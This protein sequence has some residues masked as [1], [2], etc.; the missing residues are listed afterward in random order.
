MSSIHPSRSRR[1]FATV[2]VCFAVLAAAVP[3]ASAAPPPQNP[4][5][6]TA[7]LTC[8]GGV[9]FT[10][11]SIATSAGSAGHVVAGVEATTFVLTQV[12]FEG[13]VVFSIPGPANATTVTGCTSPAYP[14]AV[15]EGF[16]V[17]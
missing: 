10:T 15:L 8:D 1:A 4:N 3:T 14:G 5:A 12:E 9:V 16:L 17:P 13:N 7:E 11:V 6:R 2:G